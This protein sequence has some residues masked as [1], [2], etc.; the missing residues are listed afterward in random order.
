WVPEPWAT[1]LVREGGGHVL[2]D[3]ADLWPDGEFVTTHLVVATGYL[4]ENPANVRALIGGLLD[5]IDAA[6]DD[7]AAAQAITNTGIENV[8][9]SRLADDTIAGAWENLTFTADPIAASLEGSKDDAVEVGL[10]DEVDLAG[11][12]DLTILNELLAERGAEEVD[13]L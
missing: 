10:L 7:P 8:T 13:G 6:N 5:A 2:V 3:E 9:T 12:Y 1:R 4:E 11:I